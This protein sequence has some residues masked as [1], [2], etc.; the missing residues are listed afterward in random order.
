MWMV[1]GL[2]NPGAKYAMNRHN[3][4]FMALDAYAVSVGASRWK[5][6]KKAEV[7]KLKLE[8]QEV[9]FVKPQTYMNLSGESVRFLMDYYKIELTKIMVVHDDIDQGFGALRI[10]K[11]R[12]A[13]GH[14]GL[15]SINEMLGTQ[16]YGR[17]KM[18]VGRPTHPGMDVAAYV[19]QNFSPDEQ[20]HLHDFL[21]HTGNAIESLIL[22]GYDKTATKFTRAANPVAPPQA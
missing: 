21:L 7:L 9:L 16:D 11:N 15:K 13:G 8:D 10:H 12:G 14:N 3:I 19:L 5:D 18:G 2:G 22:R 6:E 17:I 20:A 1:I 4:G